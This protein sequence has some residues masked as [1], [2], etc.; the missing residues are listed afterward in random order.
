LVDDGFLDTV[1]VFFL[2][3]AWFTLNGI[4]KSWCNIYWCFKI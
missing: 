3:E 2:N 1:L 4:A